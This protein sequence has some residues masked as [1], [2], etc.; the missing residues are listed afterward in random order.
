VGDLEY[1]TIPL[2]ILI[3]DF[4]IA[5]EGIASYVERP[6]GQETTTSI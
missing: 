1:V 2:T 5:T 6:F 3:A 4:V